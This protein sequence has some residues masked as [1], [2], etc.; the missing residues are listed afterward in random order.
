[1]ASAFGRATEGEARSLKFVDELRTQTEA[2]WQAIHEHAFVRGI[3][4]G[5][6]SRDRFEFYLRQDYA[7]LIDFSRVFGV[8]AAKAEREAT[9]LVIATMT[10]ATV[11]L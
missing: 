6:L 7:Y 3:G 8:A 5:T 10:R 9:S 4:D 1:M 11:E 2:L